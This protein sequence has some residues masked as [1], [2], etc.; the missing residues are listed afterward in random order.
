MPIK[1]IKKIKIGMI[2]LKKKILLINVQEIILKVARGIQVWCIH[3]RTLMI[4]P[5]KLTGYK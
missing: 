3:H 5:T 1:S 4:D 2:L